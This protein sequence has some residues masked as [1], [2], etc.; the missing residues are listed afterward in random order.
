M[1]QL[2]AC[3]G[4]KQTVEARQECAGVLQQATLKSM[5]ILLQACDEWKLEFKEDCTDELDLVKKA[6]ELTPSVATA[7]SNLWKTETLNI[8]R[9]R[10][11]HLSYPIWWD[12]VVYCLNN[13]ERFAAEDFVPNTTDI[14]HSKSRQT[15]GIDEIPFTIVDTDLV[16]I[17]VGGQ[18]GERRKWMHCMSDVSAILYVAAIDEYDMVLEED[19][20]TNR[21]EE[22]LTLFKKISGTRMHM[23]TTVFLLLNKWDV[24]QE[25]KKLSKTHLKI[26]LGTPTQNLQRM[27]KGLATVDWTQQQPSLNICSNRIIV[28]VHAY[29]YT[30]EML[31]TVNGL[32]DSLRL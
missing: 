26:F 17:D 1:N 21:L 19:S 6:E 20:T 7:I 15:P 8:A 14:I 2:N 23:S 22:S 27:K 4:K 16:L 10:G 28:E 32:R 29:M 9:E 30:R 13:V 24:F 11:H 5:K 12:N 18:R 25:K 3:Y 31:W